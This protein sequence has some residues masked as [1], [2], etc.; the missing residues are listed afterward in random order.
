MKYLTSLFVSF[1]NVWAMDS[2]FVLKIRA[3]LHLPIKLLHKC[4]TIWNTYWIHHMKKYQTMFI[5]LYF[6]QIQGVWQR[7]FLKNMLLA[8]LSLITLCN[9]SRGYSRAFDGRNFMGFYAIRNWIISDWGRCRNQ[10]W[11]N[12]EMYKYLS[13]IK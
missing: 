11:F 9:R 8:F 6:F 2:T 1:A 7:A 3:F 12:S 13:I 5:H 4:H 10:C